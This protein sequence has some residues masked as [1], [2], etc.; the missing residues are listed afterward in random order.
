[1]IQEWEYEA[2]ITEHF[3]THE[4]LTAGPRHRDVERQAYGAT[5]AA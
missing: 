1:M 5:S 3:Y 2:Y 4:R